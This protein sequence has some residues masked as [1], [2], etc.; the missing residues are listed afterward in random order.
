VVYL[1]S[2]D[3]AGGNSI[4]VREADDPYEPSP[5]NFASRILWVPPKRDLSHANV[6][7]ALRVASDVSFRSL[8]RLFAGDLRLAFW[9]SVQRLKRI[10]WHAC[11]HDLMRP[12]LGEKNG[13]ES[14]D[15]ERNES[16]KRDA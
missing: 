6:L 3:I 7:P 13:C 15:A 5:H 14:G 4:W 9:G 1:R 2:A 10:P 11:Q 16:G 12:C 8:D